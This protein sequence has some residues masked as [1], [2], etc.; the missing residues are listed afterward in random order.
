[1]RKIFLFLFVFISLAATAQDLTN[2]K[3]KKHVYIPGTHVYLVP[4]EGFEPSANFS[5][6]TKGEMFIR[7]Y[8]LHT[9]YSEAP[10]LKTEYE[11]EGGIV[12]DH[13]EFRIDHYPAQYVYLQN[14]PRIRS[15]ILMFGDS[16]FSCT[17]LAC[18]P[19]DNESGLPAIQ[20][21]L[22]SVYYDKTAKAD[23]LAYMPFTLDESAS[24]FRYARTS[25]GRM[26][27]SVGGKTK[28]DRPNEPVVALSVLEGDF[29][30]PGLA[31][32]LKENL[33]K[34]GFRLKEEKH[35]SDTTIN[36]KIAHQSELYGEQ[37]G[38]QEL[39]YQ[40]IVIGQN[41]A[42]VLQGFAT[43]RSEEYLKAFKQLAYTFKWK[44]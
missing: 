8:D 9:S 21:A 30:A 43:A 35:I 2:E 28:S 39:I 7:V 1:M 38:K 44:Q 29:K 32:A 37:Q 17:V 19:S 26:L 6:F 11:H 10:V 22:E 31:I 20:K 23:P 27:Y 13:R 24:V 15:C 14:E 34:A 4:P 16:T 12:F 36:G 3:T 42:F 41:K 5:G 33:H 40:L 18:F 25:E